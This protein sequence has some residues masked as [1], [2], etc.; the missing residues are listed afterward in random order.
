MQFGRG[1]RVD[2]R[3]PLRHTC[4]VV[5]EHG[6]HVASGRLGLVWS[7]GYHCHVS[8]VT[9]RRRRYGSDNLLLHGLPPSLG[10]RPRR[11]TCVGRKWCHHER[12]FVSFLLLF[13]NHNTNDA[14]TKQVVCDNDD[15]PRPLTPKAIGLMMFMQVFG[16]VRLLHCPLAHLLAAKA[17]LF[18]IIIVV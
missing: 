7:H 1:N 9:S 4:L 12:S 18:R 2:S 16:F 5:G 13:P 15:K 10:G 6:F 8:G 17:I 3:C 11:G 14:A